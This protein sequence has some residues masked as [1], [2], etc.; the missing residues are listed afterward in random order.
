[1]KRLTTLLLAAAVLTTAGCSDEATAPSAR[2]NGPALTVAG[3][4][5]VGAEKAVADAVSI[6]S[7]TISVSDIFGGTETATT[8]AQSLAGAGVTIQ[9]VSYG[10]SSRA[11]G[12]FAGGAGLIGFDEGVTLTSGWAVDAIGPN[13]LPSTSRALGTG[14]D[15]ALS[16]LSGFPTYDATVLTFEVVPN[17]DK[18]YFEYVFASEEYNEYVTTRYNDV[19]AFYINGQNCALVGDPP[20]P[21]T[22]NTINN[23]FLNNG[24]NPKNP[25]KYI[26]NDQGAINIE[27]DGLTTVLICEASVTPN[28]P[29]TVRLAIADASDQVLDSWVFIKAG[30]FSTTPPTNQAPTLDPIPDQDV[31][32]GSLLEFATIAADPDVGQTLTYSLIGAPAGAVIDPATGVFA[33]TPADDDPTATPSDVYT[34]VVRVT[35]DAATPASAERTVKIT[36]H[37]VAPKIGALTSFPSAP[38]P[39]GTA[40]LFAAPFTDPGSGDLFSGTIDWGDGATTAADIVPFVSMSGSHVYTVPGVYAVKLALADDDGGSDAVLFHYVVAFDPNDGFVTGGGWIYSPSGAYAA[41]PTLA[42]RASFGFVSKYKKGMTVPDGETEFQF[43]TASL[44]FHSTGYDWLVV[45][46]PK[47]QFKGSGT[48]NGVGDYGFLLTANDGQLNG[49]GGADRFRIKIWDKATNAVIY[50]NQPADGDNGPATTVLGGGSIV[51]HSN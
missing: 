25:D 48:I 35:D 36:V 2:P 34:A 12:S 17:A 26:N 19:F 37:N 7:S 8:L 5:R 43:Q 4:D 22:I 27:P 10:G 14:G 49:G 20:V 40:A 1:M 51:I 23:G 16:A 39:I 38:V 18:V 30:S 45:A 33:W 50:D 24:V 29:N 46:G 21:V 31:A 42:G 6:A 41:D 28:V 47:A 9:N 13:S 32:E 44:R 15:A 3:D 11:A